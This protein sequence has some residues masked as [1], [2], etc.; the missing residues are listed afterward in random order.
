MATHDTRLAQ[1]LD[2][3][4]AA[5]PAPRL[6]E[7]V[8]ARVH[9][10]AHRRA[11]VRRSALVAAGVALAVLAGAVAWPG[12]LVDAPPM[13][14]AGGPAPAA[15]DLAAARAEMARLQREADLLQTAVRRATRRLEQRDRLQAARLE[16]A[17]LRASDPLQDRI[18]AAARTTLAGA[19]RLRYEL[20]RPRA[21]EEA[22]ES[23]IATFP[24]TLAAQFA[25]RRLA[26]LRRQTGESI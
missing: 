9:A 12:A 6:P 2:A 8:L 5:C 11:R 21:A 16:L 13:P 24:D 23:V 20:N 1:L 14:L 25:R 18:D 3:A 26:E 4:D 7:D 15:F 17:R 10:R 22:Y 19:D